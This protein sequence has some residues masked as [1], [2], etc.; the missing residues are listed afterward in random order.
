MTEIDGEEVYKY[1]SKTLGLRFNVSEADVTRFEDGV[2]YSPREIKLMKG[3][4]PGV[5]KD[6]H[7]I[8]KIFGGELVVDK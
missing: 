6:I 5:V 1:K 4:E 8:K 3:A 2:R 7:K